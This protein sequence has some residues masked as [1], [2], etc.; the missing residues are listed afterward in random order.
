MIVRAAHDGT[1]LLITQPDHARLAAAIISAWIGDLFPPGVSRAVLLF[2]IAQHDNGWHEIDEA[3][4]LNAETGRP[5]DFA[6]LPAQEKQGIWPRGVARLASDSPLA[7]AL[8]AEHA[9]TLHAHRRDDPAWRS[10]FPALEAM[11][12]RLIRECGAESG[13]GREAFDHGYRILHLAD[14]VSLVFC[15]RW[16]GPMTEGSYRI[17]MA[18]DDRL[19]V[20]PD[21]FCAAHVGFAVTA[22]A[23]PDRTYRSDGE[24]RSAFEAGATVTLVGSAAGCSE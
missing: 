9:L 18:G 3:P 16:P 6:T 15:N 8:V 1:L 22:R 12:T 11:K 7:A 5:Y 2:A 14:L 20:S 24:L 4:R 10:F 19:L 17:R 21:P 13:S 23:I